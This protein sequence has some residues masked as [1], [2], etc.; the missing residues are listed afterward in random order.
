VVLPLALVNAGVPFIGPRARYKIVTDR[1]PTWNFQQMAAGHSFT[2]VDTE[3]Q[4]ETNPSLIDP[5]VTG[6][7][8]VFNN[9]TAGGL[10]SMLA[11]VGREIVVEAIS[12]PGSA[13]LSTVDASGDTLRASIAEA[14]CP[15]HLAP[16]E[17][18]KA[19][20]GAPGAYVGFLVRID[21]T[22]IL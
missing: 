22:T 14:D 6:G 5:T 11:N 10:F 3:T 15:I 8:V 17:T 1:G 7:E 18:L 12:N 13:T 4:E 21:E 9:L 19:V 20:G 16:Y 2:G